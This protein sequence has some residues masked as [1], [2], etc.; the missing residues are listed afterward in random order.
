MVSQSFISGI[1]NRKAVVLFLV[2]VLTVCLI[3]ITL[4]ISF[5][6]TIAIL[7]VC[8]AIFAGV[9]LFRK[10]VI[11][12]YYLLAFC[13]L[14][15]FFA[16][17]I[18]GD[19]PYGLG[20]EALLV[21]TLLILVLRSNQADWQRV[22][23]ILTWLMAIWLFISIVEIAN[24]EGASVRG[25]FQEV[26]T[27][28]I[29]P[30]LIV[31]VGFLAF[32][33]PADLNV[34]LVFILVFSFL[35]ALNG[36]KQQH[37]GLSAGEQQFLNDGGA[38]THV[39]FGKL[40]VFS[41]YSDAGQFGASQAHFCMLAIILA[42]GRFRW[43]KRLLLVSAAFIF[44]YGMLISG[45]RG[46][47]FALLVAAFFALFLSKNVKV[48]IIG[49]MLVLG[50]IGFLKYTTIGSSN[51]E[52]HRLRTAL[53][54]DDPSLN[55]R[56]ENQERLKRFMAPRPFGGGLGVIGANGREYNADKYL[57]SVEPDSYWVKVWAMYG[58]VGFILW[59]SGMMFL[60]GRG[61]ALIWNLRN[62]QL[63]IKCIAL[64]S[65]V[66]GIFFCSYGNEVINTM[67]SLIVTNLS[68]V[69]VFMAPGFDK[70]L[71]AI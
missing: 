23:S 43:W 49:T 22:N 39:L 57:S 54:P 21:I 59:F 67:P 40:R 26:R 48:L 9:A 55:V 42:L 2:S 18:G 17:E 50:A 65:G 70:E 47:L 14:L 1:T 20:V 66:A 45:T 24:P 11:G 12:V 10:P 41:F 71:T 34:F 8:L 53:D 62:N 29:Y 35:A 44:L 51:Y 27:A 28:A 25:W 52:I 6:T 30:F 38:V 58:I 46:A 36:I 15:H 16:R 56:F 13:F 33:K 7:G 69:F 63:R 31:L 5:L 3:P 60:L 61:A 64:L 37:I 32:R 4:T 68:L 19:I